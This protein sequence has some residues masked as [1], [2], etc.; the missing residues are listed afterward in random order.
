M[1]IAVVHG[2]FLGDSGS[3]IYARELAREFSKQGHDVTL[4][5]QDQSPEQYSFIDSAYEVGPQDF[6]LRELFSRKPLYSGRCRLA[7]PAIGGRL[8]TYV[9]GP[10]PPFEAV[11]F[12]DADESWIQAYG[13]MNVRSMAAIF[14][15]WPQDL[16][17]ANHAVMQP[18]IVRQ[19]LNG[20]APYIATIHGSELNFTV[21]KDHRMVPYM[22]EG[23][24]GAAAIAALSET[25]RDQVVGLA[26]GHGL[27][28][29]DKTV[30]LPPGVDT[31]LF[32]PSVAR[33]GEHDDI[34]VFAIRGGG[35]APD[36]S[37][38]PADAAR[39][40]RGWSHA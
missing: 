32:R 33:S 4:I 7:R 28:I 18:W 34:A 39:D 15:R 26:E 14:D 37:E 19:A 10:F 13:D 6:E 20:R 38:T 16:V 35:T 24:E 3:A 2:Y 27:P 8:L 11:P 9:S 36:P 25:S 40:C 30:I 17:Q 1:R 29:A 23:L 5:C 31:E 21:R 12:Q 22:L